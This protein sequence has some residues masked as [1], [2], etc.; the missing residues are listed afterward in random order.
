MSELDRRT[1]ADRRGTNF[2]VS[3]QQ[4]ER[5][6]TGRNSFS[7]KHSP[8]EASTHTKE[9]QPTGAVGTDLTTRDS[10]AIREIQLG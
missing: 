4:R 10:S 3:E 6:K 5:K 9:R 2:R 8:S 1:R 7:H